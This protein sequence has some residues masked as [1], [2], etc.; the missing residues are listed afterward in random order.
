MNA[1]MLVLMAIAACAGG[2][3]FLLFKASPRLTVVVW[4]VVLFFVPVWIG[5]SAGFFWAAITLVTLLAVVAGAEDIRFTHVDLIV[6][7]FIAMTVTM[8]GLRMTTLSATVIALLEWVLPYAWGRIVLAKVSA[9]FLTKL[10][11]GVATAAAVMALIEFTSGTNFFVE[12]LPALNGGLFAEWGRLQIRAGNTRAEGAWGHSIALGAAMAMSSAFVIAAKWPVVVRLLCLAAITAATVVTFSRIGLLTLVLTAVLSLALL[13][14]VPRA[15]KVSVAVAGVAAAAVLVP[16]IGGVFLEAGDEAGGSA[17]YRGGLFALVSQVQLFGGAGDWTGLT[18]G[19]EYLGSYARSVD[20][21]F[22]VFALRFG[23]IPAIL[24]L[25]AIVLAA[26]AIFRRRG[27]SP[28]AI[29]VAA[30]L[31]ALFAVALI[32]QFGMML[33]FLV[34]LA[35]AWADQNDVFRGDLTSMSRMNAQR[36]PASLR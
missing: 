16:V 33:W 11:A 9:S 17:D 21:A 2:I 28:A 1:S 4:T 29:A 36:A 35:V 8:F 14:D 26:A 12:Y 13:R 25:L 18:V 22:L 3:A 5:G 23:W 34:G 20:N 10:I 30:Q 7:V 31:P 32:T 27:A 15:L 19:G 6:L 24:L